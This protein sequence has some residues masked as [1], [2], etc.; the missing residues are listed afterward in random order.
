MVLPW[1]VDR[2]A[3][4]PPET[5]FEIDINKIGLSRVLIAE[6]INQKGCSVS[7]YRERERW[8]GAGR[9]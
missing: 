1:L 6:S 3:Q 8:E 5:H 7:A 9:Q 4:L 2:V